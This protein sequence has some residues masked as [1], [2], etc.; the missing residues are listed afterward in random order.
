[1]MFAHI[2]VERDVPCRLRDG[3]IL[4]ADV[5]R[6]L[7]PGPF[8]VLL[9][10]QPYG[11]RI[12]STVSHA[13]PVWY[14]NQGYLV[15]IQDVRGRGS[16]EGRFIPFVHEA[17]DGYDAVEWAAALPGSNGRVGMYGFSYQGSTQ[18]AAAS[19]H[20]PHLSAIAPAMCAAD[21]YHDSFYPHGRFDAQN[22]K[23][24]AYQLA[25]DEARKAQ[26][27]DAE[28]YCTERMAHPASALSELPVSKH[29]PVLR[30]YAPYFYD[31]LEHTQY[32][33]YWDTMNW[34]PASEEAS[35]PALLI[36]GWYD[37]LLEGTLNSFR[38]LADRP[39]PHKLLIGPWTHI[40]WGRHAGGI[41]HGADA[42]GDI[43]RLQAAWFDYWLKEQQ[44]ELPV[45][46]VRSFERGS[47]EWTEFSEHPERF[48]SGIPLYV[49]GSDIPAN[50]ASGGGRL[51]FS[52]EEIQYRTPD[53]FV[54]DARLPMHTDSFL[55]LDRSRLQ[56]RF[57]LLVFTGS[58]LA[59]PLRL[60]GRPTVRLVCQSM[61]GPTDVV[62]SLSAV[63]PDGNALLQSIGRAELK[64]GQDWETVD[65][66]LRP[67]SVQLPAGTRLRL[68]ITGSAFPLYLRHPNGMSAAEPHHAT[69]GELQIATVAVASSPAAPSFIT[70]PVL[71]P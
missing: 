50:G 20:P 65:I 60:Y 57:E 6:P 69:A 33:G 4:Y 11:K 8:P 27:A 16:S 38:K 24:W 61:D 10:R 70:L 71:Q 26:D 32:D 59:S 63:M 31:W 22:Q 46:Q 3:T 45:W 1:M 28:A 37:F 55:P 62:A 51:A 9:M 68:D 17:E 40:P 29:D 56:D 21:L 35:V 12:A 19:L 43:H 34:L 14:A 13:H 64:G 49:G 5:Y 54:Y 23:I 36:G 15:V 44:E 66:L 25:R 52:L 18:W 7:Q 42:L 39:S 41:D 67:L 58:P 53:V 30:Q 2:D 48:V 47:S